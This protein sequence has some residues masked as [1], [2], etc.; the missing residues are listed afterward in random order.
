[1]VMSRNPSTVKT[2]RKAKV[3]SGSRP[4]ITN[5]SPAMRPPGP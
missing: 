5:R 2:S 1:V 3:I 4:W